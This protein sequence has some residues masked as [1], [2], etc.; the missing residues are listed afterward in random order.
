MRKV[1]R[2]CRDQEV[3]A[4]TYGVAGDEAKTVAVSSYSGE[5][6]VEIGGERERGK[7][8]EWE[9]GAGRRRWGGRE[10]SGGVDGG[11]MA[12]LPRRFPSAQWRRDL[13]EKI[14]T[15]G[16]SGPPVSEVWE[17]RGGGLGG[18]PGGLAGWAGFGPVS[19]FTPFFLFLFFFFFCFSVFY[20]NLILF[21]LFLFSK[22]FYN[23]YLNKERYKTLW[24]NN[25]QVLKNKINIW[26]LYLNCIWM[27]FILFGVFVLGFWIFWYLHYMIHSKCNDDMNAWCF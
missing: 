22:N 8:G 2:K 21:E 10:R 13:G 11:G 7:R 4:G 27:V 12:E 25:F 18:F 15:G 26:W 20:L 3:V 5:W 16:A 23:K 19:W 1:T 17:E 24:N 6:L 9:R 14:L